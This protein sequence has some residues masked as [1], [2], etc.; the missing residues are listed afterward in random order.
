MTTATKLW[1]KNFIKYIFAYELTEIGT[2]LLTFVIPIHILITTNNPTLLGT[3]L[4]LNLLPYILI[5]PIGG[6]LADRVNKKSIIV[7]SQ[8]LITFI[9]GIY[10]LITGNF[11]TYFVSIGLLF[12][13]TTLQAIQGASFETVLY[14]I[15]PIDDLMKANSVTYIMMIGSGVLIPILSGFL[16]RH[17]GLAFIICI[18]FILFLLSSV[19]NASM[20]VKF[21]QPEKIESGFFKAVLIDFNAGV[22][23]VLKENITLKRAT[24]GIFLYALLITP[25]L[26]L[27][28]SVLIIN[29]LG[30]DESQLGLAQGIIAL[31]GIL[32]ILMQGKFSKKI[33]VSK[34]PTMLFIMSVVLIFTSSLFLVTS[35]TL[36]YLLIVAGITLMNV[37]IMMFSLIYFTYL[38]TNTPEETVGKVM[39]FAIVVMTLGGA[40]AQFIV[41]R[42]FRVVGD[43]LALATLILP[44]VVL[45]A[46]MPLMI[47][48]NK[49]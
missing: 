6:L 35:G 31:G 38:G 49:G 9:I 7:I 24:V 22:K 37:F 40:T 1:N 21:E 26:N 42:L 15:I 3:I 17:F 32:G 5:T 46:S 41:S 30:M 11:N 4:T 18:S 19:I 27:I 36:A 10:I 29:G 44:V 14:A 20:K 25:A 39:S 12:F 23:Y 45:L 16:L 43:H 48:Q 13:M 8:F 28:P 2:A 47:S 34:F 33:T